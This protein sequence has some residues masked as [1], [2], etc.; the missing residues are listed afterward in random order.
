VTTILGTLLG[1]LAGYYGGFVDE[2]IM[3]VVEALLSI[4]T[5]FLLLV[6]S[7]FFG[8]QLPVFQFFGR[9]ISG[10]V[11]VIIIVL[12]FTSWMGLSRLV[13]ANVL[14]LKEQ[15]FVVA[16]RAMG[17]SQS[18]IIFRHILPNTLAPVIV[19]A[20]LGISGVIL[21]EAYASF[22]GLG[23]QPPTASWGNMVQT[24]MERM[25]KAWWLWF[26]P[27]IL[28]LMTILGVNFLGDGLR[29]ALDPYSKK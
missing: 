21:A 19:S 15:E 23:V 9:E 10:S 13:R 8:T 4:P 25:D 5:L 17:G 28:I 24:A 18:W 14:S 2:I 22:L 26:F 7:K 12:G 11:A 1:L 6:F 20:T 29:D 3:R 27:G 16:A